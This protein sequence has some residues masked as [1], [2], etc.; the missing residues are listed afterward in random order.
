MSD[1]TSESAKSADATSDCRAVETRKSLF[2]AFGWL[3][4]RTDYEHMRVTDI[5][6]RANVVRSTFY[7]HFGSKEDLLLQSIEGPFSVLAACAV[8]ECTPRQLRL[9]LQHFWDRRTLIRSLLSGVTLDRLTRKLSAMTFD[10]LVSLKRASIDRQLLRLS[11]IQS[12]GSQIAL[13]RVW[14]SG[15]VPADIKPIVRLMIKAPTNFR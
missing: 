7:E 9:T 1:S 2:A 14:L 4:Q 13:V 15:E 6:D 10:Q 5:S 8:G 11:A 12:A 3:M